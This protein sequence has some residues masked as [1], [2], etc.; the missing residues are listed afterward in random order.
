MVVF[1]L[2]LLWAGSSAAQRGMRGG[3]APAPGGRSA[4]RTTPEEAARAATAAEWKD[5]IEKA[6]ANASPR[7]EPQIKFPSKNAVFLSSLRW[8]EQPRV[9][10]GRYLDKMWTDAKEPVAR[11]IALAALWDEAQKPAWVRTAIEDYFRQRS[12]GAPLRPP[13]EPAM[14]LEASPPPRPRK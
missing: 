5:T 9:E 3:G 11:R 14:L 1:T 7:P 10:L 12:N 13:D 6:R 4:P 8:A 2:V